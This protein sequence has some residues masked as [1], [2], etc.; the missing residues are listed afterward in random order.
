MVLR[1]NAAAQRRLNAIQGQLLAARLAA[2]M[3]QEALGEVLG[4]T[5]RSLRDW[6]K[7]YDSPSL[8]HAFDWAQRLGFRLALADR[9]VEATA[10][11]VEVKHHHIWQMQEYRLLAPF[12]KARRRARK[13]SQTDL[14]LIVGVT[15]STL[16]RWED[17]EQFPRLIGL[18]VWADRLDY[19]VE[20]QP[21]L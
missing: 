4:V 7:H 20:L 21:L 19:S 13:I 14:G 1:V 10:F 17:G 5:S 16:Q 9:L 6:E 3:S 12:L 2:K 18:I 15:R 11:P 8:G